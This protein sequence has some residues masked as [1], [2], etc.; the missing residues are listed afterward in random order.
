MIRKYIQ[1]KIFKEQRKEVKM[2]MNYKMKEYS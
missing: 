2:I 1:A